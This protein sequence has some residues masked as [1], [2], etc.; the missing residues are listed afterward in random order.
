L[1]PQLLDISRFKNN[2]AVTALHHTPDYFRTASEGSKEAADTALR[3]WFE[4]WLTIPVCH[5]FYM[6]ASGYLQLMG[7][8]VILLRRAR[9]DL[10]ARYRLVD[11][12][13]PETHINNDVNASREA[14]SGSDDLM[15]DLL[16]RLASRLEEARAEMAAA[17]CA[18]WANDFLNLIAWKLKERKDC[19]EKW[20][21]IIA[22]EVQH[23]HVNAR[24]GVDNGSS[25]RVGESGWDERVDL[26]ATH[27]YQSMEE[28]QLWLDPLEELLLSGQA[29]ESWLVS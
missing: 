10:L 15:L 13:P 6:P 22:N 19:I 20:E 5:F 1:E 26:N 25:D 16:E 14:V 23:H 11:A 8:T 27:H 4:N 17:L 12:H 21:N 2:E 24:D 29:F 3:E 18:E 9:L 28:P 7:A